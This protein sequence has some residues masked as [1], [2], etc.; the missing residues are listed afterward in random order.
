MSGTI[1][2][3]R[4]ELSVAESDPVALVPVSRTG[5]LNKPVTITYGI[6]SGDATRGQDFVGGTGSV[7]IPAGA[8]RANI[9]VRI[10]DDALGEPTESFVVSLIN[11]DSGFLSAPRTARVSIL[12]DENPVVD[13]PKPSLVSDYDVTEQAILTRLVDPIDFDFTPSDERVYVAEKGGRISVHSVDGA[14]LSEF[15]DLS[16]VVNDRQD[17]GLMDIALH[18]DFPNTPYVYA[19]YVVDPPEAASM[20]GN[21]G[22]DGGGNRYAYLSRFTADAANDHLTVVEGS[23]V[24]LVGGTG[25]S[26]EDIAGRGALDYTD[27]ENVDLKASDRVY[28]PCD[29]T[30]VLENGYKQ[31]YIKVDSRSHAGGAIAF[32]PDG[33]LYVSIGDGTS[34]N[35]ADPRTVSVQDLDSLAGK[36]LRIDPVSGRGLRDNPFV[37]AGD[38]LSLNRSKVFQLGLRNPFSMGFDEDDRLFIAD[39]GWKEWEEINQA[40]PGTNFGWPFFEGGDN[41]ESLR[42][43]GYRSFPEAGPFYDAVASGR[44]D[45]Q[46]AFRAFAHDRSAPGF[47]L[48][49]ITAGDVI[50]DGDVYPRELKSDYFFVD[51]SQGRLFSVDVD[52]RREVKFLD[53]RPEGFG[54]VHFSE[55]PDGTVWYA[56]LVRDEIGRLLIERNDGGGGASRLAL[57]DSARVAVGSDDPSDGT[58]SRAG[59]RSARSSALD[60]R[61]RESDELGKGARPALANE[62]AQSTARAV[63]AVLPELSDWFGPVASALQAPQPAIEAH[64]REGL[65]GRVASGLALEEERSPQT[66][67]EHFLGD[68]TFGDL[69]GEADARPIHRAGDGWREAAD[70]VF[71]ALAPLVSADF[72]DLF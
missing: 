51:V 21:A 34:F 4:A 32:G 9:K 41:G 19:F 60:A 15:I 64:L 16:D 30:V 8:E 72:G 50:Y 22:R 2:L 70:G 10:I 68:T 13:P 42:T 49:A 11:L 20:S 28:D 59:D 63:E 71:K 39:T 26:N 27:P 1:S 43:P 66:F 69:L 48:Q 29:R 45:V 40:G 33:A 58:A 17:R 5:N 18:P 6:T 7:T 53:E 46:P 31:D 36:I 44:I 24:V 62:D 52:D 56:D 54:Q 38:D 37:E 3:A 57:V 35:Y 25:Q 55:G 65:P 61:A 67:A 12:D 14:F 47:S 23:E